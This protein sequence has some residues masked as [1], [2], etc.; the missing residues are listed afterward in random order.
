MRGDY[1]EIGEAL[2]RECLGSNAS[3]LQATRLRLFTNGISDSIEKLLKITG[4]L[5]K[6]GATAYLQQVA[7]LL[8]A[9]KTIPPFPN[10]IIDYLQAYKK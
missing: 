6:I 8:A 1:Q 7:R 2:L 5:G 9:G 4:T 3:W 10:K